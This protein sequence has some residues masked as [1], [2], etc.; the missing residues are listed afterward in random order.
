MINPY[1]HIRSLVFHSN[2]Q[3]QCL[4]DVFIKT[5]LWGYLPNLECLELS[6]D[7]HYENSFEQRLVDFRI[8]QFKYFPCLTDLRIYSKRD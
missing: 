1:L 6:V 4:R 3:L 2:L 5:N 8:E 7:G